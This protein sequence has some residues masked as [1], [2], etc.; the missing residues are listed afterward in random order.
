M[1]HVRTILFEVFVVPWLQLL[2]RPFGRKATFH[3]RS[4]QLLAT[5]K[6]GTILV[7]KDTL[8]PRAL[9]FET[10][11][12]AFGWNIPE[13]FDARGLDRRIRAWGWNFFYVAGETK[14]TVFGSEGQETLHRGV[15]RILTNLK[16]CKFNSLQITRV[17]PR[18]FLGVPYTTV[19]AHSRHIQGSAFLDA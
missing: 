13:A 2:L 12:C 17:T 10:A 6:Q 14:A 1:D 3:P 18:H 7:K 9:W 5:I 4:N 8:L 16:S 11:P 15:K 19:F